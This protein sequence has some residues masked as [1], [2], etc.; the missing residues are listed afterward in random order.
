MQSKAGALNFYSK[1]GDLQSLVRRTEPSKNLNEILY[2][3]IWLTIWPSKNLN[4]ILYENIRLT[5]RPSKN[6][7][8]ILFENIQLTSKLVR[9]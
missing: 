5:I 2:E 9:V 8:E 7:N 6:L 1:L 4:E 3:D